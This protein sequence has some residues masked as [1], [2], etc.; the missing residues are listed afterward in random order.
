[1]FS[2]DNLFGGTP[3]NP[4]IALTFTETRQWPKCLKATRVQSF[5]FPTKKVHIGTTLSGIESRQKVSD[6]AR[7]AIIDA[8][9]QWLS[10]NEGDITNLFNFIHNV[11]E[12][13]WNIFRLTE[14]NIPCLIPG[15]YE[16]EKF[17]PS[18]FWRI[19]VPDDDG[20]TMS[21]EDCYRVNLSLRF[22][23]V[24]LDQS[25]YTEQVYDTGQLDIQL[26]Q[27]LLT[28]PQDNVAG[29]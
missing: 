17:L 4:I 1:M 12:G 3:S 2:S 5:K 6:I 25:Y 18:P 24:L 13:S 19:D 29:N 11:A 10:V 22:I 14:S 20:I 15:W 26:D 7:G 28:L 16:Y 21:P 27:P 9:F 23:N 8:D